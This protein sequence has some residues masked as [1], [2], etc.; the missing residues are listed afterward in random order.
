[1]RDTR[2]QLIETAKDLLWD[3]GYEAMSPRKVLAASGAGQ[4]SLYH[5]F[6]GKEDLAQTALAEIETEMKEA[7]EAVFDANMPPLKRIERYLKK[8][9]DGLKGCRLGRLGNEQVVLE[10][11]LREPISRYFAFI[12]D[13]L[14]TALKEAAKNGDLP[15]A[16]QS[17]PVAAALAATIQGGYI[18]S[19]IY[20]DPGYVTKAAAGALSLLK[21]LNKQ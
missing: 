13:K 19:R 3:I 4:G 7:F 11:E 10:T 8:E 5:H 17:K 9:R 20:R 15:N 6:T 1:M 16:V 12:E 18:Q 14:A 2:T 21:L